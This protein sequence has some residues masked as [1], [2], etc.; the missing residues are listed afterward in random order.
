MRE[1][2]L[3]LLLLPL[4]PRCIPMHGVIQTSSTTDELSSSCRHLVPICRVCLPVLKVG[5]YS[6]VRA[7]V[8]LFGVRCCCDFFFSLAPVFWFRPA[9][10]H[11]SAPASSERVTI[12]VNKPSLPAAAAWISSVPVIA[13][14]FFCSLWASFLALGGPENSLHKRN[15][16]NEGKLISVSISGGNVETVS[17]VLLLRLCALTKL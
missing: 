13:S 16:P 14:L 17:F 12:A 15:R 1:P 5:Q 10:F 6:Q 9:L 2:P 8:L 3:L 7:H 11:A 4:P